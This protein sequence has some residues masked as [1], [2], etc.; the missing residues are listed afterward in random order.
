MAA[1]EDWALKIRNAR[2]SEMLEEQEQKTNS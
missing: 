1:K 2:K